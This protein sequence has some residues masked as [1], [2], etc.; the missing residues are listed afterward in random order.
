MILTVRCEKGKKVHKSSRLFVFI[1]LLFWV[2][3]L[4][5]MD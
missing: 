2:H 4:G 1:E 5:W 3:N